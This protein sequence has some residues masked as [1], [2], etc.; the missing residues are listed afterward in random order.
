MLRR[1]TLVLLI[2]LV[3]CGGSSSA[4]DRPLFTRAG[5]GDTVFDMPDDVDR[6]RITGSYT[7]NSSNFIVYVGGALIVNELLGTGWERT[8]FT[9]TYV[10]TGGVTEIKSST[11]VAWTFTEVR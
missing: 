8:T 4:P 10:V 11:G 3:G 1:L 6:V 9:G 2:V 5:T 7:A